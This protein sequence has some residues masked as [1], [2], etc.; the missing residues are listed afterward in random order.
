MTQEH[1][2]SLQILKITGLKPKH[3]A[4]LI[5]AVQLIYD[6]SG[7]VSGK[8]VEVDWQKLGIPRNVEENLKLL[9]KQYQYA[10]PHVPPES[11]WEKLTPES[12]QW[13]IENKDELWQVEEAFPALDED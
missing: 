6:P 1:D 3:F 9:G 13:F 7:G 10:S 12:R 5:R 11:V 2:E 4:D 8:D